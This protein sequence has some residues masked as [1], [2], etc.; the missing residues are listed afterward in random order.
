M[1]E[2]KQRPGEG[3]PSPGGEGDPDRHAT[4]P[5]DR[6]QEDTIDRRDDASRRRNPRP[7]PTDHPEQF[8]EFAGTERD[9]S[10]TS[11]DPAGEEDSPAG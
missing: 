9:P 7:A 10:P 5:R 6:G 11:D 1:S 3:A 2:R 8:E 4:R